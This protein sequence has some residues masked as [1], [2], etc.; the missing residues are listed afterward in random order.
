MSKNTAKQ[1]TG[2]GWLLF[3]AV[4]IGCMIL[5][6]GIFY[7]SA[8]GDIVNFAGLEAVFGGQYIDAVYSYTKFNIVA[9]LGFFLPFIGAVLYMAAAKAKGSV[10]IPVLSFL[11]SLILLFCSKDAFCNVNGILSTPNYSLGVGSIIAVIL[12][13]VGFISSVV[14]G[15]KKVLA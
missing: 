14:I 15:I 3:L 1:K 6:T 2:A 8:T 4:A 10:L 9:F 5:P 13:I 11:V 7:K 12:S